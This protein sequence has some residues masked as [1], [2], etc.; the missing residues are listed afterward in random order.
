MNITQVPAHTNNYGVG[1]AGKTINKVI[2][3]WIVGSLASAD[4]TFK[5]PDRKASAHYGIE[6]DKIHQYVSEV[7]TAWHAG[8]LTVNRESIGIEHSGGEFLADK[9]N[10]RIPSEETHKTSVAL[11]AQICKRY[12]IPIDRDHI[13]PHNKFSATTCP[14]TL[15]IDKIISYA[16]VVNPPIDTDLSSD[17]EDLQECLR[18]HK[19]LVDEI[20]KQL[21][22]KIQELEQLSDEQKGT[23]KAF[24][25]FRNQIAQKLACENQTTAILGTIERL[26]TVESDYAKATAEIKTL[27]E[28][29]EAMGS[30]N[31]RVKELLTVN[32]ELERVTQA[33]T[34]E[35]ELLKER[36]VLDRQT[37][38]EIYWEAL[39]RLFP[40]LPSLTRFYDKK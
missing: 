38:K 31:S 21:K 12:N 4:A 2:V 24:E 25:E 10:R 3:H 19:Q 39:K 30:A 11:V 6:D 22:P 34:E 35:V 8:N 15:S 14:G 40:F 27:R 13:L 17:S 23:I 20:D 26:L 7:N 32:L 18:I 1:R 28:E 33:L 16:K 37:N 36:K 5:N 9:V 29:L